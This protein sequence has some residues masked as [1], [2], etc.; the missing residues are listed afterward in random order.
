MTGT[1]RLVFQISQGDFCVMKSPGHRLP[2]GYNFTRPQRPAFP[3]VIS[4]SQACQ[5][6]SGAEKRVKA[7][8]TAT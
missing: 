3:V 1:L 4:A 5:R 8:L 7:A 2:I 6:R